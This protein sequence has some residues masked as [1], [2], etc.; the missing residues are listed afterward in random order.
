MTDLREVPTRVQEAVG[1]RIPYLA[2]RT[3]DVQVVAVGEDG[4]P[5]TEDS[6]H[7]SREP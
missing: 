6:V 4:P 2:G 3:E 5:A 7:G 1:E